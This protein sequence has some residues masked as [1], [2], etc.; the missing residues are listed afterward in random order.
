MDLRRIIL[1]HD[2]KGDRTGAANDDRDWRR[3]YARNRRIFTY[4][5][6][7]DPI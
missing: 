2:Q 6:F 1:R 3:I 4:A 7:S 5:G